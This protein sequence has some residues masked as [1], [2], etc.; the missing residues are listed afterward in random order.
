MTTFPETRITGYDSQGNEF[1]EENGAEK[2]IRCKCGW[3][4]SWT[5]KQEWRFQLIDHPIYGTVAQWVLVRLDIMNH[6]CTAH[7]AA[8]ERL[9][10]TG[11]MP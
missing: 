4:R 1:T 8:M 5:D 6:S 7:K 2:T 9:H 11:E 10:M 3:K